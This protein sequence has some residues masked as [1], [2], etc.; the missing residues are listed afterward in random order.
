MYQPEVKYQFIRDKFWGKAWEVLVDIDA[1]ERGDAGGNKDSRRLRKAKWKKTKRRLEEI[2]IKFTNDHRQKSDLREEL[3]AKGLE[4]PA[5]PDIVAFRKRRG[6]KPDLWII[7][8]EG[9]SSRQP[10]QKVYSAI[11]QILLALFETPANNVELHFAVVVYGEKEAR[12][13]E[14]FKNLS[15]FTCSKTKAFDLHGFQVKD[16]GECHTVF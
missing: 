9:Q 3:I 15:E 8:V 4:I 10:E 6:K 1:S 12:H 11:G 13:L 16:S 2:G 14:R 7:E 5:R